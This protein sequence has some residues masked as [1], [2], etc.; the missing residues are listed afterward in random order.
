MSSS[1]NPAP[2]K[3]LVDNASGNWRPDVSQV[4]SATRGHFLPLTIEE[5][6]TY[7]EWKRATLIFYVTFGF[8]I[9]SLL[10]A[11]GPT[12]P[13]TNAKNMDSHSAVASVAHRNQR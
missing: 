10:I 13:T 5:K 1:K 12:D 8:A 7:R 11:I 6:T 9:A 2:P 4:T 3:K